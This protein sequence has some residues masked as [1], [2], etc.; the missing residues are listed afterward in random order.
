M[1]MSSGGFHTTP[2]LQQ[3][4]TMQRAPASEPAQTDDETP[5]GHKKSVQHASVG[6][7]KSRRVQTLRVEKSECA[8]GLLGPLELSHCWLLA[9]ATP[10]QVVISCGMLCIQSG[11]EKKKA[12]SAHMSGWNWLCRVF[13]SAH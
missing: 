13:F 8:P 1:A 10:A 5:S 12:L 9:S 4:S 11:E 7:K 3:D 2:R 6:E